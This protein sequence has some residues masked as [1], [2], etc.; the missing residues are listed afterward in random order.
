M[1][2]LYHWHDEQMVRHEMSE[3]NR[4]VEQARLLR[5]AGLS[6][7]SL[8]ARA[9]TALGKLLKARGQKIKDTRSLEHESYHPI[10]E[11]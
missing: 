7:P 11:T 2:N 4:V 6:G 5:D 1:N 3:V 9:A 10:K 8:L